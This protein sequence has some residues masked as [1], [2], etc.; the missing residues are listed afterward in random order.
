[1][2]GDAI[3]ASAIRMGPDIMDI[4]PFFKNV[5]NLFKVHA[6]PCDLQAVLILPFLG[7]KAKILLTQLDPTMAADYGQLKDAILREFHSACNGVA[8]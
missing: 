3:R 6:V 5:E 2:F 7:D 4:I 8:S 1:M